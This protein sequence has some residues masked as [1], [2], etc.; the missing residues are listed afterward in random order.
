MVQFTVKILLFLKDVRTGSGTYPVSYS[1]F[2]EGVLG[3]GFMQ[4]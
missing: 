1:M 2:V 4:G 3:K